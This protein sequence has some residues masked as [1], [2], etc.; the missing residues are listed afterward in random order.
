MGKCS[1]M[2]SV[3]FWSGIRYSSFQLSS[4]TPM[5]EPDSVHPALPIKAALPTNVFAET[6]HTPKVYYFV[7]E[8]DAL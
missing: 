5:V 4:R 3:A 6:K 7:C 8:R 1:E 2:F